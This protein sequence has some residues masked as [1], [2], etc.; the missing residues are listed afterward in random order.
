MSNRIRVSLARGELEVEGDA[1]FLA[2]YKADVEDLLARLRSATPSAVGSVSAVPTADT[3]A[4]AEPPTP[5][6]EVL[7]SMP[8]G[9]TGTDQM[10]VAGSHAAQTSA[11]RSFSTAEASRLLV[12]QGVKLSN[13]SQ[14]IKN[15]LT[16]KRVFKVGQS[17]F[18]VSKSGEEYLAGLLRGAA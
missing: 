10:L 15:C 4:N 6:G 16:A 2:I 17:R 13:P 7:N 18:R 8:R 11:D 3:G 14:S 5:F 9:A 12:E 1:D